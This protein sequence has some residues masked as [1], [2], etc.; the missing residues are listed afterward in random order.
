MDRIAG[1]GGGSDSGR[2]RGVV[3]RPRIL[4]TGATGFIGLEVASQLSAAGRR[5]RLLVRRPH[6]GKL[7][8]RLDVEVVEGDLMSSDSLAEAV[9]GVDEVIHLAARAS[10]ERYERVRP[11]IVDGSLM[12]FQAAQRAG[13]RR[14]VMASS[15]LVYGS[16]RE[17]IGPHTPADP[18]IGYGRAKL[19]AE[20]ALRHALS[21]DMRL[22]IVRLPHVYGSRSFLFDQLRRGLVFKPGNGTNIHGHLQVVD[23][24]RVLIAAANQGW[25]GT[26]PV[27]D[28]HPVDWNR[29]FRVIRRHYDRYRSVRIPT[30]VA[31]QGTRILELAAALRGK[32]TLYT[33]DTVRGW[34]LN[35]PVEPG[36]L[37][38]DLGLRPVYPS[39]EVGVPASLDDEIAFR[40]RHPMLDAADARYA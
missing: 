36:V 15:L 26:L 38:R 39:V 20:L 22:G 6:R 17:P 10:F 30:P 25:T 40:W 16:N 5:P 29:F 33:P 19:E 21:S 18:Q 23:A 35:L 31:L 9:S 13:V 1:T 4:V 3:E 14:F 12:L 24:A 7:F 32:P 34:I 11:S 28:D 27:A 37:W 2:E 8:N